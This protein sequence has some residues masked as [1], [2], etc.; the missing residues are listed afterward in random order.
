MKG[1]DSDV[2]GTMLGTGLGVYAAKNATSMS[3]LLWTLGK[4]ALVIIGILIAVAVVMS[5]FRAATTDHFVPV[6]PSKEGD[7]KVMTPAGNV[8]MY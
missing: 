3:G 4:Y 5:L 2:L 6:A 7:E 1:G 8:I